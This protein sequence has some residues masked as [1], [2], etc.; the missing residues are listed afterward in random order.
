MERFS[1]IFKPSKRKPDP[2]P[3][4][5]ERPPEPPP[6]PGTA[7]AIWKQQ[8]E[9]LAQG[10]RMIQLLYDI[11]EDTDSIESAVGCMMT[12]IYISLILGGIGLF[13]Y[14]VNACNAY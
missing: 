6:E 14:F 8:E 9:Q 1:R 12:L 2:E 10:R 3:K 5:P 4:K 13:I 11:R 7:M